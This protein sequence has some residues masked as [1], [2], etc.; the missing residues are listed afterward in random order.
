MIYGQGG[1]S[2]VVRLRRRHKATGFRGTLTMGV[3][4]A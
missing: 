4:A 3:Q 1:S 2:S